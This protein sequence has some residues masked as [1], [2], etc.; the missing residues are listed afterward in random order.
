MS[1]SA[2]ILRPR[3]AP[4]Y[5]H[6]ALEKRRRIL[7][8]MIRNIGFRILM[9]Y[10]GAEGVEN[11]P[12]QGPAIVMINHIAFV[13]PVV[14]MGSLPR[15]VVPMAKVEAFRIPLWGIFPW[16][17]DVIPVH[18]ET[19]DRKAL[20]KALDVL[21]AGEVVLVA[22]EGTRNPSLQ[23]GKVGVAYLASRTGAPV[24][25]AAVSGTEGFPTLNPRRLKGPGAYV[26]IGR[27][28]RFV[29]ETR[30]PGRDLLRQMTDEAMYV[31]ASMLP[32][33]R[34]GVYADLSR[35]T[36]ATISFM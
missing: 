34:R 12:L 32:P 27:P 30:R 18:R 20:R 15:N 7:R 5:D 13:D 11:F 35:A 31:L 23:R 2:R 22:P 25:P 26:R 24:V 1:E 4:R 21:D 14:V 6:A 28:F 16:L 33:E 3:P 29:I 9:R 19:V 17:W 36:T 10:D 8:W